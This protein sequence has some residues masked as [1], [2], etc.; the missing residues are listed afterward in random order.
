M[1]QHN[2]SQTT[3]WNLA[4]RLVHG[5]RNKHAAPADG[6]N[7]TVPP[8]HAS[9][10]YVHESVE[11]LDQAF[12]GKTS[13]GQPSY[14]Y[15][16]QGNPNAYGFESAM[17]DIEGGVG[18]VA[19]GSGMAA[20]HAALLA[21]GLTTGTKIVAS[22]DLYGPTITLL[23]KLFSTIGT[24]LL[25]AD[26]CQS[27]IYELLRNEEPDVIYVETVSNPLTRIVDLD[28]ISA[29]ARE[30]GAVTIVDST[31][32]TPYLTRPIEHGFD[33]VVH[34]A[35]KYISGHG[36]STGGVVISAKNTLLN[37]LRD[38][39]NLLGA[40]LSPFEAHLMLRGLRT[41]SL[42]MERQCNNALEVA[43]FLQQHPAVARVH[44][45]G[46]SDYPSHELA[47]K[48]MD[49]QQFGGLLAFELKEQSREAAFRFMNKLDLCISAT[50][51]GDVFTLVSY[52][53]ISSHRTLNATELHKMGISDGCV[54][55]SVGI[56]DSKDIIQD[57][58]QALNG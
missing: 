40:M 24:Q 23:R 2:P 42:R 4:T 48:L 11:A 34:S 47:C 19:F 45:P 10:T 32:S 21:A 7:P 18:A 53:P 1:T 13:A 12:S 44:Y 3:E 26:F 51:L 35:T 16:R 15:A 58:D 25:L 22:Q 50:S 20:M 29:V 39:S 9:T 33:L 54:R 28:A 8:I 46:L 57:L 27:E 49:H 56:E 43:R 55:L 52:P 17:A 37:Q 36:D 31:F 5:G 14:V 41:L 30:I 38:Y 6:G